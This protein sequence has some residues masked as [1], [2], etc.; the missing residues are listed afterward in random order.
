MLHHIAAVRLYII[1][2]EPALNTGSD[3]GNVKGLGAGWEDEA[4]TLLTCHEWHWFVEE[5]FTAS[6][7]YDGVTLL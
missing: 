7:A 2:G 4:S 1:I 3:V 6:V 5:K